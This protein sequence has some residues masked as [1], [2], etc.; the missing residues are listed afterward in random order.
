MVPVMAFDADLIA[1]YE[2]EATG[3]HRKPHGE[4]RLGLLHT[5]S[6]ILERED[7]RRLI[8]VGAGPGL[9]A[10]EWNSAGLDVVGVDLVGANAALIREKGLVAVAGSLYSLP[11]R[12]EAFDALWT[13]STF[14][15]VP[16]DR[17]DEAMRELLRVVRPGSPL[18][19]G[20][21]GGHDFEGVPEFG[22][23]R[24]YRFFSLNTDDRWREMLGRHA[25]VESF[26]TYRPETHH[27][28]VYQFAVVRAPG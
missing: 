11:F 26:E 13:M 12:G 15:H 7:R 19:I 20:T 2:A 27:D 16:N 10:A 17:F 25:V 4:F 24:P 9:D 3:G 22:E 6:V 1:Y 18:G 14:V 21:W 8:D 5:F 23:L 28:W